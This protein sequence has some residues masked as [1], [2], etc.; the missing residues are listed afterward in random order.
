MAHR[1]AQRRLDGNAAAGRL[2]DI[3]AVDVTMIRATCDGC[4]ASA[5]IGECMVYADAPGTVLRCPSCGAVVIRLAQLP[6][7]T[8]LDMRGA[9]VLRIPTG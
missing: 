1:V 6:G 3:F 5:V 7:S 9:Q 8:W 2:E 4:G